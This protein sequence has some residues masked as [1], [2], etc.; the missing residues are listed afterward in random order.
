MKGVRKVFEPDDGTWTLL[1]VDGIVVAHQHEGESAALD[2]IN[3]KHLLCLLVHIL[4]VCEQSWQKT[5]AYPREEGLL[6]DVFE[7]VE[8][9][10]HVLVDLLSKLVLES[11]GQRCHEIS[12]AIDTLAVLKHD[13]RP[14]LWIEV[15][16]QLVL[17]LDVL[18]SIQ[19]FLKTCLFVI[20]IRQ[21]GAQLSWGE[22]KSE[23][24]DEK[25]KYGEY[26]F[27]KVLRSD[28]TVAD[29]S[30]S[31]GHEVEGHYVDL[32]IFVFLG[33]LINLSLS[34]LVD[35]VLLVVDL[36]R[37]YEQTRHYVI[38]EEDHG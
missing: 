26:F 4:L 24:A 14:E 5:V 32:V 23:Y 15:E 12:Q 31:C 10:N 9:L 1:L 3:A 18:Q 34:I 8:I 16:W 7:Q 19:F 20:I 36:R 29:R 17:L 13:S 25:H 11:K 22:R 21:Y 35:P 30:H 6:L 37:D 27:H 28:V 2:E 33:M 38:D